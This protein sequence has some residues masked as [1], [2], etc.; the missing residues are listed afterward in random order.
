ME[1][2]SLH[3]VRKWTSRDRD[4][5]AARSSNGLGY[6]RQRRG[7]ANGALLNPYDF[8]PCASKRLRGTAIPS[9]IRFDLVMPEFRIGARAGFAATTVPEAA[10]HEDGYFATR[11]SEIRFADDW[12][13][14]PIAS[15]VGRPEQFA[16]GQFGRRI[17]ARPDGGHDFRADFFREAIHKAPTALS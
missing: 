8:P 5:C 1:I 2:P 17:T 14:L 13:V 9:L 10:V 3:P 15:Q 4:A 7:L 12:P 16:E 11:P 6:A